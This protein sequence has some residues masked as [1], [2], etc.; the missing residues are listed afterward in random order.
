MS[1]YKVL[2][3]ERQPFEVKPWR[4]WYALVESLKDS[5]KGHG[6]GASYKV[7]LRNAKANCRYSRKIR[8][9]EEKARQLVEESTKLEEK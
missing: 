1:K 8:K 5:E 7:A 2:Q 6:Y 3:L 4:E 9:Q